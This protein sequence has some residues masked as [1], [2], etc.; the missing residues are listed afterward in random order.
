MFHKDILGYK[1]QINQEIH[2]LINSTHCRNK[3]IK[4]FIM[5]TA[6]VYLREERINK[7]V[8][9]TSDQKPNIPKKIIDNWQRIV[10]IVSEILDVPSGLIMKINSKNIE[11]FVSSQRI[12]N[13]YDKGD[14]EKLKKGLYCETVIGNNQELLIDDALNDVYWKDNPDVKLGMVSYYGLPI[15]WPDEEIFGT[16]CVLDNKKNEYNEKHKKLL[17]EFKTSIE[18]DLHF[19][20][21]NEV[22]KITA[23]I[24]ELTGIFNRRKCTELLNDEIDRSIRGN[25]SFAVA[26]IDLDKFKQV[27]DTYGHSWGDDLLKKITQLFSENIRSIDSFCRWGGDEFVLICPSTTIDGIKK[28]MNKIKSE[29]KTN[30][31]YFYNIDFSYGSAIYKTSDKSYENIII[32]C[33]QRMYDSKKSK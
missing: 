16:I 9:V 23:N 2:T 6:E 8:K 30:T 29:L 20:I 22:L 11:V 17:K 31:N 1:C 5:K 4:G 27:N 15:Q 25:V 18:K 28:I 19:I 3:K 26:L 7:E 21:V 14:Q 24:D 33:D 10:N 13:P 12:N 32:R